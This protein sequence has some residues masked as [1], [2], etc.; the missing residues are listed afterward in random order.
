MYRSS[1]NT[2]SQ[3]LDPDERLLWHGQ[4]RS[5]IRLRAQDA[6]LI[7][8]SIMW[9]GFAIFWE[10]L[11]VRQGAPIF[12]MLWGIPFICVGL[13]FVFGRFI[14]D[15]RNRANTY[16]GVTGERI[17]IISGIFS[18]QMK[19][20]PLR[21]LSD[22]S[23][24]QRNDGSG[25]VAFGPIHPMNHIFPAGAWPGTG[26]YAPPSFDLIER[27]KEAYDIIRNAQKSQ[28]NT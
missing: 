27:A 11:A 19:S 20:L 24:T 25:T 8:F 23:L 3:H 13:F 14:L 2:L 9:C 7:P 18:Q 12:F 16:Y 6:F 15:A 10:S 22:I 1:E 21:T 17:L 28:F 26:R 5:G 4:P